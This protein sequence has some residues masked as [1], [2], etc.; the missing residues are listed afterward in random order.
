MRFALRTVPSLLLVRVNLFARHYA[1]ASK[2]SMSGPA[3]STESGWL[4][5]FD[6]ELCRVH[7]GDDLYYYSA[8]ELWLLACF[9]CCCF[10]HF[11]AAGSLKSS[12]KPLVI[13]WSGK[14][15]VLKTLGSG[16]PKVLKRLWIELRSETTIER[17][18]GIEV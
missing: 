14:P 3:A 1:R 16:K 11:L 15:K 17:Q 5:I 10:F 13:L 6:S 8:L 4:A 12:F 7:Y 9:Q 18:Q 2:V